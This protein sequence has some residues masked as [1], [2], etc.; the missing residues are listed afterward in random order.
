[1]RSVRTVVFV[2]PFPLP[3]TLEFARAVGNLPGVRVIG[4]VMKPPPKPSQWGFHAIETVADALDVGQLEAAVSR[5]QARYGRVHRLLGVLED[6]QLQLSVVRERMSI[7]GPT[8]QVT[9][10][11]RDKGH[12]KDALRAAGL[13]CAR[14]ARVQSA[15]DAWA[16]VEKVGF[17]VVMKPPA[18][19]GCRATW[20]VSSPQD[21]VQALAEYR[22]IFY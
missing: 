18:G 19:A 1:M 9:Q 5:I 4:V 13:P 3:T 15:E 10:R 2:A 12:M 16:F 22:P 20:R 11:F 8:P 6:V 17:P 14:H 7:P 21:L